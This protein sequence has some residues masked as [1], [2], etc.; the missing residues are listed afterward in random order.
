MADR[1]WAILAPVTTGPWRTLRSAIATLPGGRSG[2][3]VPP[4]RCFSSRSGVSMRMLMV[5]LALAGLV[6]VAAADDKK[7]RKDKE[8]APKLSV[9]DH[10]PALKAS[11]WLQ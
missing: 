3:S 5:G 7:D 6:G 4:D 9:G 8:D 1:S 2:G 11:K 10:A